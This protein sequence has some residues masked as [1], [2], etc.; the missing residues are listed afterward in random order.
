[1]IVTVMITVTLKEDIYDDLLQG[2]EG[3]AGVRSDCALQ[4]DVG[5]G[6][7]GESVRRAAPVRAETE[8]HTGQCCS[9]RVRLSTT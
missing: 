1:M 6:S 4:Q 5:R 9:S 8:H 2:T 7:G 3:A